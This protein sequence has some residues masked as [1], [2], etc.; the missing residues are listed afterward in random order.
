ML[1]L[2]EFIVMIRSVY[3]FLFLVLIPVWTIAQRPG[4]GGGRP[5][6]AN[7]PPEGIVIGKIT[8]ALSGVPMEYANVVLFS[9][10]DSSMAAGTVTDV[11]GVFRMEK[12]PYGRFYLVANFIGY[13]KLQKDGIMINPKN[14]AFDVGEIQL[15]PSAENLQAV[16]ITAERE[17]FE[18]KID[19]KIINVEKDIMAQ[20][21]TAVNALEN[22]PSVSVDIDGEVSMRGSSSF[23]VLIDG[24][25][26]ILQGTDALQQIPVGNID[27]I[28]IITNPSAKYDPDGVAGIINVVLKDKKESG[29]TGIV[30]A[31]VATGDKYGGDFLLNYRTGKFNI[32]GG[33]DYNKN[34]HTGDRESKD[35][36]YLDDT[37]QF[38]YSNGT[39][40]R[41]RDGYG[42]RLGAD[43]FATEKTTISALGRIGNYSRGGGYD[44]YMQV[45]TEP[46]TAETYSIT[47]SES[48]RSGNYYSGRVNLFHKFDDFGQQLEAMAD[49]SNQGGGDLT[50]QSESV[51]DE[52]WNI[53]DAEPIL[54]RTNEDGDNHEWR[55][56]VDYAKP[57][58]EEG[59]LEA[60][61]QALFDSDNEK[62][63][64]YQWDYSANDWVEND[65]YSNSS[66]FQRNIYSIYGIY[67]NT[68]KTFGYQLGMRGEYTYREIQNAK[69]A[70][71]S[72]IDRWDYFPTIHL[73]KNFKNK[74]QVLASY[75]RRIDRPRGWYLDPF[76]SYMD[77]Y[78]IRQGNPYLQ[79]E[80]IDSYEL[81]YQKRLLGALF[82]LEG[83]YRVTKNKITRIRT[84]QDDGIML[85]TFENLD[86]DFATGVELM[87]NANPAKWF[88]LMISGTVYDYRL[89]G[90]VDDE[91]VDTRST[92]WNANVNLVFVLP[93]EFRL[94]TNGRYFGPS[95]TAQGSSTGFFMTNLALKKDFFN[96]QLT[97]TFSIRDLFKS[98]K[99][100]FTSEGEG[101]YSYM[102]FNREAPIFQLGLS[103]KI[104]N[105][106]SKPG[107]RTDDG[108]DSDSGGE[109]F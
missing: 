25:P 70:E 7:M 3:F 42:V 83:Y 12:V 38:R 39:R 31:S 16:E 57:Y 109:D 2:K 53:V 69:S 18:Y 34:T 89:E 17:H 73:S 108:G 93:K 94:Q 41:T 8:D 55:F 103:W 100:E 58:G 78:N 81:S 49:Y 74:D 64:F 48:D 68:W 98:A 13:N 5:D 46:V 102:Y 101:F 92:N 62:Y 76:V 37:T 84:L 106:K 107:N 54:I 90:Q 67:S 43:F 56:K 24:R 20:G 75:T 95:V 86:K 36:T 71:A 27:H 45:F 77:A 11:E 63:F 22:V 82:T 6:Q 19:K 59:K 4:G 79:P 61:A 51:T 1:V 91:Q 96:R 50:D 47:T 80:Y 97:T 15:Q 21:G 72:L 33:A 60:G 40:S 65:L 99:H 35:E 32:F 44:S 88:Q 14:K 52:N 87:V 10:R 29:L 30:N 85:N 104:N 26:S 23:T 28:E 9:V 66:D 105:Y